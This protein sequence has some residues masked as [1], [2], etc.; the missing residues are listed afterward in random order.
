MALKIFLDSDVVIS[1]LIST[2]GAAF[3]L[4]NSKNLNLFISNLSLQE[5]EIVADRLSIDKSKLNNLIKKK[6]NLIQLK[7][8]LEDLKKK[9]EDYVTDPN[10]AHIVAGAVKAKVKFLTSYNIKHFRADKIKNDLNII[11]ITPANLLQYFR[12]LN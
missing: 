6:F 1:S 8:K 2:A 4:I 5:L 10:D 3:L 7:E 12:G 11:V 9:Y